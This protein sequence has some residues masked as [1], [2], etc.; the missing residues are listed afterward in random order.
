MHAEILVDGARILQLCAN[1]ERKAS[2]AKEA[3]FEVCRLG[4]ELA[5]VVDSM[6]GPN[7]ILRQK[8]CML[9]GKMIFCAAALSCCGCECVGS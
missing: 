1:L 5:R 3:K 4:A 9:Y 7:W 8:M 6:Y 2:D